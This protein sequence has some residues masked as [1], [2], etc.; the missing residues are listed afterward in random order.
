MCSAP[1]PKRSW[2]RKKSV[3]A[4]IPP[5]GV[6]IRENFGEVGWV[7]WGRVPFNPFA[8]SRRP[9]ESEWVER[10]TSPTNP[11]AS[12]VQPTRPQRLALRRACGFSILRH[13]S[14]RQRGSTVEHLICNQTVAGSIP[15]AGSM[16]HAGSGDA[17][18]S[19]FLMQRHLIKRCLTPCY[20]QQP[21]SSA[22]AAI[23]SAIPTPKG[24]RR[25]HARHATH[26]DAVVPSAR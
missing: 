5:S 18:P 21:K 13:A 12:A 25:S 2:L 26:A 15:V 1:R 16:T 3:Y 7:G 9:V 23:L 19:P 20:H 6:E 14:K 4:T 17:P 10:N 24:Q 22:A 11:S 8:R